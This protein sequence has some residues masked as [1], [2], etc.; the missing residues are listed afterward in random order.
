VVYL[1]DWKHQNR[2][3]VWYDSRFYRLNLLWE[4]GTFFIRDLHRF[5]EKLAST[6]HDS[7]MTTRAL[8][9]ETLPVMD[10]CLW[11]SQD[12]AG[13]WPV[14]LSADGKNS[15][16]K[17]DGP[18]VVEELNST[19]LSITQ[20]LLGGGTF[21]IICC[22]SKVAFTGVD[23][24]GQSLRWAWNLVGGAQQKSAVQT[25]TP[26]SIAYHYAGFDYQLRLSA[27]SGSCQELSNGVIQ[28][29]PNNSGKLVMILDGY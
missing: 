24:Q 1:N 20:P 11:S 22:E 29:S 6:T 14:L 3:S 26:N 19:D 25:V 2:K 23:R 28:L 13:I 27:E 5:D 21:A 17:P 18:P 8:A 16:L 9:Y 15:P 7:A 12:P 10:G 4:K